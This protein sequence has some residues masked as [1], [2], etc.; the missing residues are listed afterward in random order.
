VLDLILCYI[1]NFL[2]TTV[3]LPSRWQTL[4]ALPRILVL[5][6]SVLF[7]LGWVT[8]LGMLDPESKGTAILRN[9][10]NYL[11]VDKAW[12]HSGRINFKGLI[13]KRRII[14]KRIANR[15]LWA[16]SILVVSGPVSCICDMWE[17]VSSFSVFP[18]QNGSNLGL[19]VGGAVY[20]LRFC[21]QKSYFGHEYTY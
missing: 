12:R 11:P 20:K 9:F 17:S 8:L 18:R 7:S 16:V 6:S 4:P 13:Y 3:C 10:G 5:S 14:L 19:P 15:W 21:Y 2:N 1:N